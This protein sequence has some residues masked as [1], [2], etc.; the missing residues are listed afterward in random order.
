M[1]DAESAFAGRFARHQHG[2]MRNDKAALARRTSSSAASDFP[3]ARRASLRHN[4][5]RAAQRADTRIP[6]AG[7]ARVSVI[8][9][10]QEFS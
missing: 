2:A 4:A 9:S 7:T 10:S 1:A 3:A 5:L 8:R 6:P